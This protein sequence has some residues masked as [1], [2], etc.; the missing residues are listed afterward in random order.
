MNGCLGLPVREGACRRSHR[1]RSGFGADYGVVVAAGPDAGAEPDV[2]P[3]SGALVGAV[4]TAGPL[5]VRRRV[6]TERRVA[7][8]AGAGRVAREPT[9]VAL[10]DCC[11]VLAVSARPG[12][13]AADA[14]PA[15]A[16]GVFWAVC[17]E[18]RSPPEA[19]G[20]PTVE[21]DVPAGAPL[22]APDGVVAVCETGVDT[23][24]LL[25]EP[26]VLGDVDRLPTQTTV[27]I[28][29]NVTP[30]TRG[31]RQNDGTVLTAPAFE[32]TLS[33]LS[34]SVARALALDVGCAAADGKDLSDA[35]D[36]APVAEASTPRR[37]ALAT[38]ELPTG[39]NTP[40]WVVGRVSRFLLR[41]TN[42][43]G[44]LETDELSSPALASS[45]DASGARRLD[46]CLSESVARCDVSDTTLSGAALCERS[47]SANDS[48]R[49][50]FSSVCR[51]VSSE[52]LTGDAEL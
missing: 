21:S 42:G 14:A 39:R 34:R 43:T 18:F 16:D 35:P 44:A 47:F 26:V 38:P 15:P 31:R 48:P 23:I 36:D 46:V 37:G 4:V 49:I 7:R 3:A 50:A 20:T 2:A 51:S 13:D 41:A 28:A 1:R 22:A 45:S 12:V 33:C 11:V 40:F 30:M 24:V 27:T 6:G 19:G 52:S 9:R 8:R 32:N 5:G 25:D 29:A 17:A 10:S